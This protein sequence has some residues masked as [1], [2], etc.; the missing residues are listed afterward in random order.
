MTMKTPEEMQSRAFSI[1]DAAMR[2]AVVGNGIRID[3]V[4]P[5]W[6]PCNVAGLPVAHMNDADPNVV[7]AV[8]WLV[9]REQAYLLHSPDYDLI[10]MQAPPHHE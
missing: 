7:A 9:D 2:D 5:I 4:S 8:Q 1:A 10:V 6:R 3:G